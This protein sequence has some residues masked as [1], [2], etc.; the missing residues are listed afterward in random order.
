HRVVQGTRARQGAF[1]EEEQGSRVGASGPP[2]SARSARACGPLLRHSSG[3]M[4]TSTRNCLSTKPPSETTARHSPAVAA[5]SGGS[6]KS[7]STPTLVSST[8]TDSEAATAPDGR[9][10][11]TA[12]QS[13]AAASG[14]RSTTVNERVGRPSLT[15]SVLSEPSLVRRTGSGASFGTSGT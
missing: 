15:S 12:S 7:R 8:Q 4:A 2:S 6:T 13:P 3:S 14:A 10:H 5:T 11:C 9:Y 1:R